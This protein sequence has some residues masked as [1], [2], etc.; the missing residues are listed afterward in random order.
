MSNRQNSLVYYGHETLRIKADPITEFVPEL[1]SLSEHMFKVMKKNSGI[2]LA[3][4]QIALAKQ[5]VT[6]DLTSYDREKIV[7]LNPRIVWTSANNGPYDEGCLSI[8]GIFETVMRPVEV[9]V[10]AYDLKGE[11][12]EIK[13]DDILARVL[14]HE[15]D[16]LNGI[17]F[18]DHLEEY[19]RKEYTKELKKIKKMNK[20]ALF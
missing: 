16:H 18:V 17:L 6:I 2:G 20:Q 11:Q 19:I 12:I 3:A 7:I 8:P 4:P 15:I 1:V 9:V 13:A 14:Q 5:L 10:N